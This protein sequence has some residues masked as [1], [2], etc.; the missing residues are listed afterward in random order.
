[1]GWQFAGCL[2]V[3]IVATIA[4][5]ILLPSVGLIDLL[6]LPIWVVLALGVAAHAVVRLVRVEA[7]LKEIERRERD[8]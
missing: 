6:P 3:W 4:A 7:R 2:A 8:P 1:M 5:F